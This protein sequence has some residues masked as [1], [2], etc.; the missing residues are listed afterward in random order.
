MRLG[1]RASGAGVRNSARSVI[2]RLDVIEIQDTGSTFRRCILVHIYGECL[3]IL[4]VLL[5]NHLTRIAGIPR[6]RLELAERNR[7]LTGRLSSQGRI[8][9]EGN[10]AHL[11]LNNQLMV[12]SVRLIP[13]FQLVCF[14]PI[15]IVHILRLSGISLN[16]YVVSEF[17]AVL[18]AV[19]MF[20]VERDC[21]QIT[22]WTVCIVKQFIV[23]IVILKRIHY[24]GI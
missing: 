9:F 6:S 14:G 11:D 22:S 18:T 5:R 19:L 17:Q 16:P 20:R 12:A 4:Q 1:S 2:E 13:E 7:N 3:D 8:G 23:A 10:A 15:D 21:A 24:Q